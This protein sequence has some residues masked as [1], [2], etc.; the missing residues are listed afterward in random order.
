ML[1]EKWTAVANLRSQSID[2]LGGNRTLSG[3]KAA[4]RERPLLAASCAT[5]RQLP[6][7]SSRMAALLC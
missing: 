4:V 3:L 6:R 7:C 2:G 5:E 1:G